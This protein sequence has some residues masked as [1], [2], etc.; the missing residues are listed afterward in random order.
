MSTPYLLIYHITGNATALEWATKYHFDDVGNIDQTLASIVA[1]AESEL[2]AAAITFN[3][4]ESYDGAGHKQN[5]GTLTAISGQRTGEQMPINYALL[6]RL[7][8]VGGSGRPS[9]RY[10]HGVSESDVQP[11]NPTTGWLTL[12]L[13]YTI[14][15]NS[16]G[17]Y[18]DSDGNSVSAH[19]FRRYT[20]RRRMRRQAL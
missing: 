4:W 18:C 7:A 17:G 14:D 11:G 3:R 8:S 6:L 16:L 5:E 9:T 10:I 2:V 20:R 15:L 1:G 19:V 13:A 12:L